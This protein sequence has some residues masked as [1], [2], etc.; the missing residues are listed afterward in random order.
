MTATRHWLQFRGA[1]SHR[2][3]SCI[4]D[5]GASRTLFDHH[6]RRALAT[7]DQGSVF[8]AAVGHR[9]GARPPPAHGTMLYDC[10]FFRSSSLLRAGSQVAR[11]LIS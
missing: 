3:D 10:R 7:R 6:Q 9:P 8:Q 11:R 2:C 5:L 4:L 1:G